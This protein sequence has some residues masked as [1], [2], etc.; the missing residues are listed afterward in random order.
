MGQIV[1]MDSK[2]RITIPANIR[3]IVGKKVFRIELAN[4]DTIILRAIED[5]RDL[6]EKISSIK[7]VGDKERV[8]VDAATV[9]DLY[10]GFK[11]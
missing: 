2:G 11:H 3:K 1:E 5:K 9:K 8:S 4:K 7:L 10:G 6:V